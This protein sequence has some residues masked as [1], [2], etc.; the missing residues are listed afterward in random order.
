[1][2][3]EHN[4]THGANKKTLMISFIIITGYMIIEAIGGILTNSLALL[5]D[6]GHMLSDSISLGVGLLAFILGEKAADY[7]KTY[8]YKR[9]EILAAVFNGV[10]LVLI[11]IYIFYEAYQRF[12]DPPEVA[13]T[14]MLII[15]TIGLLVNI[16]V[17]WILMRGGD[18][19]ENLNIRAAFL[20]VIGDLLGSVGAIIAALMILFFNW[21]W[22]DPLASVIVAVLV[23]IS[24]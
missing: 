21:G 3:H 10:T 9:F 11:A 15:A 4:H 1:M 2:S 12:T 18:T 7:S 20:H 13:S 19:K 24:G 5:A 6:A 16:L 8:G 17:A 22:A 23:L 14:G